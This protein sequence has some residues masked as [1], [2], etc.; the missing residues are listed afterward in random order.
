WEVDIDRDG[1]YRIDAI[2]GKRIEEAKVTEVALD[3]V[4]IFGKVSAWFEDKSWPQDNV[5]HNG[6]L[7]MSV[8]IYIRKKKP[9]VDHY[10]QSLWITGRG[11]CCCADEQPPSSVGTISR[12]AASGRRGARAECV[13]YEQRLATPVTKPVGT[14][15]M[16]TAIEANH[17]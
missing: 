15:T 5:S 14:S 16:M 3:H 17:L 12:V 6:I 9:E 4:T 1:G 2:S 10:E 13:T 8:T 11:V 7:D